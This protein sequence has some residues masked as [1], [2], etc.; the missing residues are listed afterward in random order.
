MLGFFFLLRRYEHTADDNG[1][2]HPD[3]ALT[4]NDIVFLKDN[5]SCKWSD[6]P[7]GIAIH[8]KRSKTDW[9]G[10]GCWRYAN[11]SDNIKI[12]V[13][14]AL[15]A[16]FRINDNV[17][18]KH[19]PICSFLTGARVHKERKPITGKQLSAILKKSATKMGLPTEGMASHSLRVGG[20]TALAAAKV[21]PIPLIRLLGSWI[22]PSYTFM[23]RQK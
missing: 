8:M 2:F 7:D 16:W 15:V 18:T 17:S 21:P 4:K 12:C 10:N 1:Q 22:A 5:K 3:V 13:V 19:A 9:S 14:P 20:S 11:K 6:Q 23:S